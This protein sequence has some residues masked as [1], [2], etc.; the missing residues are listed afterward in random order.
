MPGRNRAVFFD[1]D[2]TLNVEKGYLCDTEKFAFIEGAPDA[3]KF[4]NDRNI[5]VIV[6][7]NQSGVARGF[8]TESDVN[9]FHDFMRKE[10][11]KFDAHIDGFYYCPHHPKAEVEKYRVDCDCRKPKPGLILK[12]CRDFDI[13]PEKA[14]MIGDMPRDPES[15]ENAGLKKG[16]LFDGGNLFE[17]VKNEIESGII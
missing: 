4:L 1:R 13:D 10:F 17:L 5:K 8:F 16:I 6:I 14:I 12:A 3:V 15:G 11:E 9:N 7:T 2:G